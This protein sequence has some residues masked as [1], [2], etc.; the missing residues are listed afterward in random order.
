M[1]NSIVVQLVAAKPPLPSSPPPPR[2]A[3]FTRRSRHC[4]R[5][6]RIACEKGIKQAVLAL[7]RDSRETVAR[8][9]RAL[10]PHSFRR[11]ERMA[12]TP[13]Q[14]FFG[15]LGLRI[16][17]RERV[18]RWDATSNLQLVVCTVRRVYK[19]AAARCVFKPVAACLFLE[20]QRRCVFS[21][22]PPR[23]AAGNYCVIYTR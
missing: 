19:G 18:K 11:M 1:R 14:I 20:L 3:S 15:C 10:Y 8:Q 17:F 12:T 16:I 13:A 21:K 6:L 2:R 22:A 4:H 23:R 9:L 5:T 7:S